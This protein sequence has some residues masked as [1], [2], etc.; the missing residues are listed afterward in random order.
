MPLTDNLAAFYRN[1]GTDQSG[2][3][4]TLTA[5]GSPSTAPGITGTAGAA[6]LVDSVDSWQ[7][8]SFGAGGDYTYA[9]W[10]RV[11]SQVAGGNTF[12]KNNDGVHSHNI[13]TANAH[14]L[15]QFRI[16]GPGGLTIQSAATL[17]DATW[18]HVAL[19]LASGTATIYINGASSASGSASAGVNGGHANGFQLLPADSS[20]LEYVG[21]WSRALSA[22]EVTQ[23]YN[24]GSG[25][26]PTVPTGMGVSIFFSG[27]LRFRIVG[28]LSG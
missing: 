7:G 4:N 2:N 23:L 5:N 17:A 13:E 15:I 24:G 19:T 3:G 27:T 1:N 18:V 6:M 21:V 28:G 25:L 22:A 9:L 8:P 26:D 11:D 16:S 12:L 14:D 20:R 10:L